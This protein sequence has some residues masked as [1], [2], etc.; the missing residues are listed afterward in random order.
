MDEKSQK[1]NDTNVGE[2]KF[3]QN[4]SPIWISN[5][6]INKIVVSNEFPFGKQDKYLIVC[7]DS[8]KLDLYAY[9]EYK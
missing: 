9:S 3:H 5:I 8:E 4:K 2:Y 6:C 1:F 7:K